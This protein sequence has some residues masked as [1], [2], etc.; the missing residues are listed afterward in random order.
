MS[1]SLSA[2]TATAFRATMT[3]ET[4]VF[5]AGTDVFIA[6]A[7]IADVEGLAEEITAVYPNNKKAFAI[8]FFERTGTTVYLEDSADTAADTM[9]EMAY[10]AVEAI[11]G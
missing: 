9:A 4:T 5:P 1:V 7:P 6:F 3:T 10:H 2:A 8:A 11:Y